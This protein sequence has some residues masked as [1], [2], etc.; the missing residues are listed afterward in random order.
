MR[1]RTFCIRLGVGIASAPAV[2]ALGGCSSDNNRN[3][4]G[5]PD[6]GSGG[7]GEPDAGASS[8]P[9][10]SVT[11]TDDSGHTHQF[12]IKCSHQD[13]DGWTYTAEGGHTHDVWLSRNDLKKIF[14]GERVTVET[15]DGHPH[16][17]IIE[18]PQDACEST[19]DPGGGGGDPGGG[20]GDDG[21][22][23]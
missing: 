2:L 8:E 18:A 15:S 16:T 1:R 10:F 23:Y 5:E 19:S 20:G 17:W 22:G 21:Y 6:A 12:T 14:D 11:N 9:S 3:P 7:G 4:P 13:A